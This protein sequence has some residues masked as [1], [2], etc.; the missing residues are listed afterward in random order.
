MYT[1]KSPFLKCPLLVGLITHVDPHARVMLVRYVHG[2]FDQSG[3]D[4]LALSSR[5]DGYG[6]TVDD[7]VW[8]SVESFQH[9]E[10]VGRGEVAHSV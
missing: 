8:R 2:V 3:S 6:S 7:R 9:T 1:Y 10:Q 4:A 5:V